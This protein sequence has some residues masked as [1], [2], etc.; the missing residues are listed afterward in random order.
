MSEIQF[1]YENI[2]FELA[3]VQNIEQWITHTITAEGYSLEGINYIFCSDEYLLQVNIDYLNHD[4]YTDIITFDNSEEEG[5]IEADIFVSIDRCR[6]NAQMQD[7]PFVDELRRVIIHGILH[8]VG[9]KDKSDEDKSLMRQK[10][11]AYLS[12]PQFQ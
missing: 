9:Y 4:Y 11:N 3:N 12:L 8:L 7:I 5:K 1:F 6:D 2:D 10:E